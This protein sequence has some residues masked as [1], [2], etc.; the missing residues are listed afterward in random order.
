MS[1]RVEYIPTAAVPT[2]EFVALMI[3]LVC[4]PGVY[5][6][7]KEDGTPLYIGVSISLGQRV[8]ASYNERFGTRPNWKN[9][10]AARINFTPGDPV[11][12]R[13]IKTASIADAYVSEAMAIQQYKPLLNGTVAADDL[14]LVLPS[15]AFSEPILCNKP[16]VFATAP[17]NKKNAVAHMLNL[18][19]HLSFRR[20]QHLRQKKAKDSACVFNGHTDASFTVKP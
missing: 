1:L 20:L 10:A 5:F 9:A 13:H 4:V 6:F 19:S 17:D 2:Q 18:G 14:T 16:H 12:L 11:F 15:L 8:V 3:S 7:C